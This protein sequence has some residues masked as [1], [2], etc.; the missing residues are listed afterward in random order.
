MRFKQCVL[1]YN[2]Q[3]VKSETFS[4]ESL[5]EADYDAESTIA[6]IESSLKKIFS[7]VYLLEADDHAL[8]YLIHNRNKI[9]LVFNYTVGFCGED[10]YLQFPAI[11]EMLS[12][13]YTGQTPLIQGIIAN[14]IF[15][16]KC[17]KSINI[18]TPKFY[19]KTEIS[20][21]INVANLKFPLIFKPSES[22]SSAGMTQDSVVSNGY[23][24]KKIKDRFE[25]LFDN[26]FVEEFLDGREFSV[27]LVGN[28]LKT[29]PIVELNYNSFPADIVKF[30]SYEIK[31]E[32]I[33]VNSNF[34]VCPAK[35]SLE[36][37]KKIEHTIRIVST[38]LGLR[39][40]ARVDIRLDKQGDPNVLDINC[41]ASLEPHGN[42]KGYC[43]FTG[44]AYVNGWNH[45]KLIL[46]IVSAASNRYK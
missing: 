35:L 1:L 20:N 30:S 43:S 3:R 6:A 14:K 26:Y 36:I 29:L 11:L 38:E 24:F 22:G 37:I 17:L 46:E 32:I 16:K 5:R 34:F 33:K 45:D 25:S 40:W 8:E 2:L 15:L 28:P 9:D 41:P 42:E 4:K 21:N 19:S 31:N 10:R 23:D 44:S 18:P 12:I 39:D 7:E 13:P 27:S